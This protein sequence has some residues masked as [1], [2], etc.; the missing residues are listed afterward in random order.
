L[1]LTPLQKS[2]GG[3]ARPARITKMGGR[4][5]RKPLVVGMTAVVRNAKRK[6]EAVDPRLIALWARKPV[7]VVTVALANKTAR[8]VWAIMTR[9]E[10]YRARHGPVLAA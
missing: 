3:K 2:S 5:L 10:V 4:Y 6:A 1:G 8:I 9:G 7:R